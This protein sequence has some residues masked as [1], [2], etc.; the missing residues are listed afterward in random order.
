MSTVAR[1]SL[2]AR[3]ANANLEDTMALQDLSWGVQQTTPFSCGAASCLFILKMLGV[4]K[5]THNVNNVMSKTS[6]A[7]PLPIFGSSPYKIGKYIEHRCQ[8]VVN[9]ARVYR[10]PGPR[11][12]KYKG[13]LHL[14]EP[15]LDHFLYYHNSTFT[16]NHAILRFVVPRS[17]TNVTAH[18][19]V[20]TH[21]GSRGSKI[22][23]PTSG[24]HLDQTFEQYLSSH[25]FM[26]TG[27]DLVIHG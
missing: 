11:I 6:S 13:W 1:Q 22:M 10:L 24:T 12:P 21:F 15:G 3:L 4:E 14:L 16:T 17:K 9:N 18:Y 7:G 25:D 20:Q 27:L 5:S 26:R 8:A 2:T 23:D 19:V